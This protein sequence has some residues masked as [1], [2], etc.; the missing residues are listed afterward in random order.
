[1][2]PF[3]DDSSHFQEGQRRIVAQVLGSDARDEG[4]VV[5]DGLGDAH[6]G[7]EE[8]FAVP[9]DEGDSCEGG[10]LSA[11]FVGDSYHFGVESDV[12][13]F[14]FGCEFVDL[15]LFGRVIAVAWGVVLGFFWSV[16]GFA[17]TTSARVAT[18]GRMHVIK[19]V[20]VEGAVERGVGGD[21]GERA[22][23]GVAGFVVGF[24]D[25]P[26]INFFNALMVYGIVR[27]QTC[28]ISYQTSLCR[29]KP[30]FSAIL[31][32]T[33]TQKLLHLCRRA[34]GPEGVVVP[35][36]VKRYFKKYL[37]ISAKLAMLT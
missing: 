11:V 33:I 27:Y 25:A 9:V 17:W 14:L 15:D 23:R 30:A 31:G 32:H 24:V 3:S 29:K 7:V 4:A 26:K 22:C 28:T 18:L 5:D 19:A 35:A 20:V 2:Y 37:I 34:I 36:N 12:V 16:C 8:G 1:M 6:V 10:V 21:G 13:R